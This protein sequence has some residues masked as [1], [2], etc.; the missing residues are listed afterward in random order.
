MIYPLQPAHAPVG[1][2]VLENKESQQFPMGI[3][4]PDDFKSQK[5]T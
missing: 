3:F 5:L 2:I 4:E 1:G